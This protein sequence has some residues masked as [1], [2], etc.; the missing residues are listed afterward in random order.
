ML[1][2]LDASLPAAFSYTVAGRGN[3]THRTCTTFGKATNRDNYSANPESIKMLF[4]ALDLS[5]H[6]NKEISF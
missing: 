5:H 3:P 2:M 4:F 6:K 1:E